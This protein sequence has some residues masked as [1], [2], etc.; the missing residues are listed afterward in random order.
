MSRGRR[1]VTPSRFFRHY[2]AFADTLLILRCHA[3]LSALFTIDT[4]HYRQL[5]HIFADATFSAIAFFFY[6]PLRQRHAY[7]LSCRY[8]RYAALMFCYVT[9]ALRRLSCLFFGV[10]ADTMLLPT[11]LML[12]ARR[13]GFTLRRA[14][15]LSLREYIRAMVLNIICRR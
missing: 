7:A 5:I 13:A 15:L 4:E 14:T 11:L 2:D 10:Y 12:M 8:A 9:Y 6:L 3:R 1:Y